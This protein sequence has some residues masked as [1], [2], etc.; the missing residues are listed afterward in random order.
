MEETETTICGHNCIEIYLRA[1]KESG[2]KTTTELLRYG[3][4]NKVTDLDDTSVSYCAIRTVLSDCVVCVSM[5]IG[6][7][8]GE[9][10][11]SIEYSWYDHHSRHT[12]SST[13]YP[14]LPLHYS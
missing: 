5:C 4:S 6:V 1:L 9:D 10:I 13:L 11:G 2:L 7:V 14:Y 3:Q 12:H 8:Y